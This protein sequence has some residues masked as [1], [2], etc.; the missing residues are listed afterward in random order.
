MCSNAC[1]VNARLEA[2][3]VFFPNMHC[4]VTESFFLGGAI[5]FNGG[6]V[7]ADVMGKIDVVVFQM[8]RISPR[9][10]PGR[11]FAKLTVI[12]TAAISSCASGWL[13]S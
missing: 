13:N 1:R 7:A 6:E 10:S 12:N 2:S 8:T 3:G 11:D 4:V 9:A 5:A